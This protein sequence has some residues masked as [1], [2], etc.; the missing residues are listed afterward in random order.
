MPA[1]VLAAYCGV[2]V[3]AGPEKVWPWV[4]Q[5]RLGPYS[6]YRIDNLGRRSTQVL[7]DLPAPAADEPF[8]TTGGRP[9]GRIVSVA[10]TVQLT[11]TSMGVTMSYML[12]PEGCKGP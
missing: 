1:P 5:I 2:T 3:H 8:S 9:V 12:V 10:P 6:D 7:H 4:A 11:A